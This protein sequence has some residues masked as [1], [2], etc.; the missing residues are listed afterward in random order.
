ME[1]DCCMLMI[2]GQASDYLNRYLRDIENRRKTEE[3]LISAARVG[4]AGVYMKS[5]ALAVISRKFYVCLIIRNNKN[6]IRVAISFYIQAFE[7]RI[8]RAQVRI[9]G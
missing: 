2:H 8:V 3:I 4:G 7:E 9:I 6:A 1:A 5:R